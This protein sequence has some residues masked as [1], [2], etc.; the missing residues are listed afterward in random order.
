MVPL[1]TDKSDEPALKIIGEHFPIRHAIGIEVV[2]LVEHG[3][4][5]GYVT[6]PQPVPK[7]LDSG[8]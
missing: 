8:V 3:G 4:A 5:I 7:N 2:A 6:Q 1:Y